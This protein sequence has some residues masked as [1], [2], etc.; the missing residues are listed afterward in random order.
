MLFLVFLIPSV[1]W[2]AAKHGVTGAGW[3]WLLANALYFLIWIVVVHKKIA[4]GLH[5][6]WFIVDI[7][8]PLLLPLAGATIGLHFIVW[9]LNRVFL[10]FELIFGL[11]VLLLLSFLQ[12]EE[13]RLRMKAWIRVKYVK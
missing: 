9:S 3:A 6:R 5:M 13:F 1:I 12:A 11:V 4:P 10:S 2:A 7:L 8:R